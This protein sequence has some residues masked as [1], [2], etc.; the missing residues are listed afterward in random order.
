M[1]KWL[2]IIIEYNIYL[3]KETQN[4]SVILFIPIKY[5]G[6]ATSSSHYH[7]WPIMTAEDSNINTLHLLKPEETLHAVF[8]QVGP[9]DKY[10]DAQEG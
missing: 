2:T 4:T 9:Q 5:Q 6:A 1:F 8:L 10:P 7:P 3:A